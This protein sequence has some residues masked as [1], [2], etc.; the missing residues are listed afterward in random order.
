MPQEAPLR[1][2]RVL[3][4]PGTR[5]G[6]RSFEILASDLT[7]QRSYSELRPKVAPERFELSRPLRTRDSETRASAIPPRCHRFCVRIPREI[8]S[9]PGRTQTCGLLVRSQVLFS[10]ELQVPGCRTG[11]E[12]ASPGPHPGALVT[13]LPTHQAPGI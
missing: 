5:A 12:P 2:S 8:P 6:T 7:S 4:R 13:E 3:A 1:L 9:G 11:I 10:T